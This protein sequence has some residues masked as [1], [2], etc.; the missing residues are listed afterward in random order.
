MKEKELIMVNIV[1]EYEKGIINKKAF[2]EDMYRIHKNLFQYRDFIR[3]TDIEKIEVS[4]E[5]VIM[6]DK[7]YGVKLICID[8][9]MRSIPL[10]IINFSNYEKEILYMMKCLI[11]EF[12]SIF[13][14]GANIGW[15]SM[16]LMRIFPKCNV[17]SFEP[18]NK[19]FKILEKN[20]DI[21]NLKKDKLFNIGFSEEN[22]ESKFYC[23]S[24]ELVSTSLKNI[25]EVTDVEVI[26][27]TIRKLDDFV[28]ET[29]SKVDVIKC[30]VEGAELLVLK[31]GYETLKR[32][33]PI[34][35]IEMLRKWSEQFNYHPNDIIDMLFE[36]GYRCF[37]IENFYLIEIF[38]VNDE[39]VYTNFIFLHSEKHREKIKSVIIR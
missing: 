32:D 6:T 4:G 15:Y 7:N 18:L 27:C 3:Y 16:N 33:T 9:D 20:F 22:G 30:D 34:I 5:G 13:D 19:T 2:I 14:I 12:D 10:E 1:D 39:T 26:N 29:N 25:K 24:G 36:I 38:T 28:I 11:G 23:A 35:F 8:N 31:G 21:N 37:A 17:Y